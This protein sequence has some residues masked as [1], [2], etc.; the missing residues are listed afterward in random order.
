MLTLSAKT[1]I[2]KKSKKLDF[3]CLKKLLNWLL[4]LI[5][6]TL[7]TVNI[8]LL[9][10]WRNLIFKMKTRSRSLTSCNKAVFL[11]NALKTMRI[12]QKSTEISLKPLWI[13]VLTNMTSWSVIHWLLSM[14]LQEC[15]SFGICSHS[16]SFLEALAQLLMLV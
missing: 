6:L 14:L 3:K 1:P 5:S 4:T 2:S 16:P 9:I 13:K 8:I 11:N 7:N 12:F 15:K 10:S